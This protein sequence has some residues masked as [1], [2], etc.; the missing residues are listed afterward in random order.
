M[1]RPLLLP[2]VPLYQA[3][4]AARNLAYA[5]RWTKPDSLNW[6]VIS[7]GSIVAGGAGKTSLV[8][9]LAQLLKAQGLHVD[10]LS[11]GY[12]RSAVSVERVNHEG[13]AR[14]FGDEPILIARNAAVP[15]Y[16]G[17]SRHTAGEL[18][19]RESGQA[20]GVHLLD[21]GFQHRQLKR[22][23]DIVLVSVA[24]LGD[25]MLPAGDLREPNSELRRAGIL[26][27]RS[28]ERQL[29]L[30]LRGRGLTQPIWVI[31][32]KLVCPAIG[33]RPLV[34]CGIARPEGLLEGIQS[35]SV[36]KGL[37]IAHFHSFPDHH[38]YTLADMRR[39]V[40]EAKKSGADCF[41]TTEKDAVK[42][43]GELRG[44]LETLAPVGVVQ[45]EVTLD[46]ELAAIKALISQANLL[47]DMAARMRE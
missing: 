17:A 20:N 23:V 27:I 8:I 37:N 41:L 34:F 1:K 29:G 30:M 39:L 19:E 3:A 22:D 5:R 35:E 42:L 32:R 36:A 43:N 13:S 12:G 25:T 21:D 40:G 4:V 15:V 46:D 18:A 44:C 26:A 24:D 45:L 10:V 9:R 14:Q 7:V 6:P 38:F 16:V 2:L 31:H 28:E 33:T 11:R 47:P